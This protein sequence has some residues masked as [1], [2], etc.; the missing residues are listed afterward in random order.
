MKDLVHDWV[1]RGWAAPWRARFGSLPRADDPGNSGR[2]RNHHRGEARP[3]DFFGLLA[4]TDRT[5]EDVYTGVGGMHFLPR[6]ILESSR[7]VVHR[8]TRVSDITRRTVSGENGHETF[9]W[10][11]TTTVGTAAFHDTREPEAV[12]EL[13]R[14]RNGSETPGNPNGDRRTPAPG[15][16]TETQTRIVVHRGFDAVV[17]TDISSS[18]GSWH[19]ASAGLPPSFAAKLPPKL[20]VP[21]FSCMIALKPTADQAPLRDRL[22]FDAF[23]VNE[24]ERKSPLWFAA[25][26]GSK[27]GFPEA[28]ADTTAPATECWTLVSTP[29]F[30]V[31][32]IRAT[33]MRDP[34][35]GAFRAQENGYLN[36][37]PG[38]ALREAFFGVIGPYLEEHGEPLPSTVYLQAQRWGSGLPIDPRAVAPEHTEEICGTTYAS[39]VPGSSLDRTLPSPPSS[40]STTTSPGQNFV[41]DDSMGLYYGGDFC[42]HLN[43]GF[44]AAALSGLDLAQHILAQTKSPSE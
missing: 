24:A 15:A 31:D 1:Q 42:S 32:E 7:A 25:R 21:L 35:T 30:A 43:P 44:E 40:S 8:G 18:F 9:V 2:R 12:S 3:T 38:P 20:R 17:F 34:V 27:P 23:V 28:G 6:K 41:A 11:L 14:V 19:R 29:S 33:T 26:S 37:G 4:S 13:K 36:S 39:G 5:G 22:P 16:D 10:D